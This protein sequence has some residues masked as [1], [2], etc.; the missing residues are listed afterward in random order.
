MN[1]ERVPV[2]AALILLAAAFAVAGRRGPGKNLTLGALGLLLLALAR[3]WALT[4]HPPVFGTFEM[5]LA[6][7]ATLLAL[8]LWLGWRVPGYRRGP[9]VVA[10]LTLLHTFLLQPDPTPLTISEVSLWIDLHA[11]LAWAAWACLFHAL[12]LAFRTDAPED[13]ALRLLGWGFL[14]QTALGSVGVYYASVLFS[15]PWAWDPVQTLGL[16]SWLLTAAA[17]HFRLFFAV[18]MRRLRW[19]LLVCIAAYVLAAKLV[20]FLPAGQS[21]HVFELGALARPGP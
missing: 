13:L 19:Y 12:L 11:V 21:F 8:G 6:E 4:G 18:P 16:L 9:L 3:R 17:L 20:M 7:T 10:G 14:L 2:L 15:R 5:D 1:P